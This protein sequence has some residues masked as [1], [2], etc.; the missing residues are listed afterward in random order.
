MMNNDM[1]FLFSRFCEGITQDHD[2]SFSSP[3]EMVKFCLGFLTKDERF[4][5]VDAIRLIEKCSPIDQLNLWNRSL[6]DIFIKN[7]KSAVEFTSLIL[8]NLQP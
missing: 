1:E 7:E 3:N 5:F 6:Q 8:R 2:L 4:R